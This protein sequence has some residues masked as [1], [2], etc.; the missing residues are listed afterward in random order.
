MSWVWLFQKEPDFQVRKIL[1][2][3]LLLFF[4]FSFS[5]L[6]PQSSLEVPE[7]ETPFIETHK[8]YFHK[9]YT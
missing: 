1:L 3:L 2:F 7:N 6:P 9:C 8:K 5:P 4:F